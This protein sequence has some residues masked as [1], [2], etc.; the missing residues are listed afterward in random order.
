MSRAWNKKGR[1][2]SIYMTAKLL[3]GTSGYS[4]KDWEGVL[5]PPGTR[6]S[7][8]LSIYSHEFSVAEL[9]FSYYR[10]PDKSLSRRMVDITGQDFVFS[11]KA[12]QSLTHEM[13]ADAL[14]TNCN[15]FLNGIEP[16]IDAQKLGAVLLQFPYSFHYKKE[17]RTYL[18]LLVNR[19]SHL[20]L[21]IE[22]RNQ[23]WQRESVYNELR[24]RGIG[25]VNVDEPDVDGLLK[26]DSMVTSDIGYIRFHG[27]N[28][29]NWWSGDNVSRYDYFYNDNE[30]K[31]WIPRISKILQQTRIILIVFNNH[32]KGQAVQNARRLKELLVLA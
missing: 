13:T 27:R 11:I 5:Y 8:Y 23:Y 12:H 7:D 24:E 22:F 18:D 16:F 32:S 31:E 17:S 2:N 3:I 1:Y 14:D 25:F 4:Y 20:P 21:C 15:E 28:A 9:N 29:A 30:L 6:Q 26:A 10:M 19:L